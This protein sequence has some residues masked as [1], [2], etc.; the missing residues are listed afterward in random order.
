[1]PTP[2]HDHSRWGPADELGAG[3]LLTAEVRLAA[4]GLVRTAASTT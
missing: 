3:N 4:L 2:A 1:M